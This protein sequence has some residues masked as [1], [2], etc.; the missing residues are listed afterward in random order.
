MSQHTNAYTIANQSFPNF[1]TDLNNALQALATNNSAG[2]TPPSPRPCQLWADTTADRMKIRDETT[3]TTWYD[4]FMLNKA[5]G[6]HESSPAS[7]GWWTSPNG[8]MLQ[9]KQQSF[10]YSAGANTFAGYGVILP[11]TFSAIYQAVATMNTGLDTGMVYGVTAL[12]TN[13]VTVS[14]A[15]PVI[16][17]NFPISVTVFALGLRQ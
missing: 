13:Q 5:W 3:A 10:S 15:Y 16:K 11:Y 8:M 9:W 12:A 6:G 4:L 7:E 14:I 1:R 17:T 2:T